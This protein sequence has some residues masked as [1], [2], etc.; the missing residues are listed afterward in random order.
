[1]KE[2]DVVRLKRTVPTVPVPAGSIGTIVVDFYAS[3][4]AHEVEF[5]VDG[6]SIGTYAIGEN[7]LELV[8]DSPGSDS[9]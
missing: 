1:M 4:P 9:Q 6:H 2:L 8:K 3:P 5:L 7:D